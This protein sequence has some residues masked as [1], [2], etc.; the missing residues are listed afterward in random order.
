MLNALGQQIQSEFRANNALCQQVIRLFQ[1]ISN[2]S[3]FRIV[4]IL[5]RDEFCV[6]DIAQIVDEGKLSNISQQLRILTLAG[7]VARRR[8]QKKIIY[9]LVDDRVRDLIAYFRE[10]YLSPESQRQAPGPEAAT[11]NGGTRRKIGSASKSKSTRTKTKTKKT[12]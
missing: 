7:V 6:N 3:R 10:R 2:K 5:A 9:R 4:C 8:E 11:G 1:L 12:P